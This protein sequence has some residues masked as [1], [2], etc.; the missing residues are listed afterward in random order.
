MSIE[1]KII[2]VS[3]ALKAL[4]GKPKPIEIAGILASDEAE[5]KKIAEEIVNS[6]DKPQ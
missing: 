6:L 5:A 4:I 2:N 3:E 1:E